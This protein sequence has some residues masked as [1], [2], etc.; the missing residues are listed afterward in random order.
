MLGK[1]DGE[2]SLRDVTFSYPSRP[3]LNIYEC[4]NLTIPAG[5][6]VALVGQSGCGK[7]TAISLIER[8]Y[9]PNSGNV[10]L[11]HRDI[12]ECNIQSLRDH[13]GYVGQEPVLFSGTIADNIRF[14]KV[15]DMS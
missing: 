15:P 14:G 2:L 11:D 8:F 1:V 12:R 13:V 9:D 4:Y 10:L 6:T 7:S 3:H 5:K